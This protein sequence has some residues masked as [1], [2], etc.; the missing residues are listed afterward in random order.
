MNMKHRSYVYIYVLCLYIYIY[1][2]IYVYICIYIHRERCIYLLFIYIYLYEY[3]PLVEINDQYSRIRAA[4]MP[5]IGDGGDVS[6]EAEALVTILALGCIWYTYREK[7]SP[8]TQRKEDPNSD[9]VSG[10]RK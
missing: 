7:G 4:K 2:Y 1:I 5:R 3:V 6:A 8:D 10:N 9:D